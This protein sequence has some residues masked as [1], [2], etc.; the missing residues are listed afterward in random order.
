M[1]EMK[2]LRNILAALLLT[3]SM[4]SRADDFIDLPAKNYP[5]GKTLPT[6]FMQLQP[7]GNPG[8]L[9]FKLEYPEY[10]PL[11]KQEVAAIRQAGLSAPESISVNAVIGMSRK[12]CVADISFCPIICRKGKWLR[13]VSAKITPVTTATGRSTKSS[14][15]AAGTATARYADN[16]V[17]SSGKWLKIRVKEEGIYELTAA[18]L[19]EH[20]FSDINRVKIFGYGGRILPMKITFEG[21]DRLTDDLEEVATLKKG[22]ALLFFAEGTVRWSYDTSW[23]HQQNTYSTHSFYFV[24]EGENPLRIGVEEATKTPTD[25]LLSVTHNVVFENDAF[26]WYADGTRMFD[27]YEFVNGSSKTWRVATPDLAN[28][29]GTVRI[30][31]SAASAISAT[32]TTVSMGGTVLGTMS[33]PKLS[34][35]ESA[36]EAE[37]SYTVNNLLEENSIRFDVKTAGSGRLDFIRISYE[38]LLKA[39][40]APYSFTPN[41]ARPQALCIADATQN[42]RLWRIAS[43]GKPTMEM[44]GELTDGILTAPLDNAKA[45][46]V[47]ADISKSYPAPEVVGTIENQNLHADRHIDMVIIVPESGLLEAEAQRLADF[48][49]QKQGLRTKVVRANLIFNEFS[50]GTPDATAYRRYL[51]MLY[52]RASDIAD[53]PRYLLLFGDGAWDNRMVTS[54]WK[55]RN[56]KD[57]LLCFERNESVSETSV[58]IG[59]LNSYVTDD[60][61]G[62]LDDGEGA[63]ITREKIDL[64]IGRFPVHTAED[65]KIMVDKTIAYMENK[66]VG[67]WKNAVVVMGDNGDA[68][69]HMLDA[70]KACSA[71]E[72]ATDGKANITRMY[73]DVYTRQIA[74]TGYSF[75]QAAARLKEL[76]Q[77]GAALFNYSGHGSPDQISHSKLLTTEELRELASAKMPMWVLAS[78]EITPYDELSDNLGRATLVNENGGAI[79]MFCASRAVYASYN[80]RINAAICKYLFKNDEDGGRFSIGDATRMAKVAMIYDPEHPSDDIDHTMNKMKYALLGDPAVTLAVP[81]G[82]IVI[83]SINGEALTPGTFRRLAAGTK[84]VFSGHIENSTGADETDFNGSLTALLYD[85]AETVTCKNNDNSAA[86]PMTYTA[87]TNAVAQASD[88]VKNGKFRMTLPI[89]VDISYSNDSARLS[90]YAASNDHSKERNGYCN[91]FCLNG[92][93]QAI[94]NDREGPKTMVY[95]NEPDFP[96]GGTVGTTAVFMAE[97]SDESGINAPLKNVGHDIEL[98]IDEDDRSYFILNQNFT[99]DFGS[100]TSGRVTYAL[101]DLTPGQH[102]LRFRVWDTAGN[103]TTKQL[104]FTVSQDFGTQDFDIHCTKSPAKSSTTFT[105]IVPTAAAGTS[106]TFEVFDFAGRRIWAETM[107][108]TATTRYFSADWQLTSTGGAPVPAGVYLY[109]ARFDSPE[110]GGTSKTKKIIVVR[111]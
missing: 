104:R 23:S 45:R 30:G 75:P 89:P 82:N 26:G 93:S 56:P 50:S 86:K 111:Q 5:V 53:A 105:A 71:I 108:G 7:D 70:E 29:K 78:C 44:K 72:D 10:E 87:H 109:R 85:R 60:Y 12:Q 24:T 73:W 47:I 51:K 15:K 9:T 76:I 107:S 14:T 102:E 94:E 81:T 103:A 58:A 77:N 3:L 46:Y 21:D 38:R 80:N 33:M 8:N 92:T 43:A 96:D 20:G 79:A 69:E 22:N 27:D 16:S 88:S 18:Q 55:N 25:T 54:E 101:N 52:D 106:V 99:Y 67:T 41:K 100:I 6:C 66:E 39:T 68:N 34:S 13:L 17:L 74:A 42:T 4:G 63:S 90:L 32:S 59:S 91:A 65:A 62:L 83:D 64:G 84:A 19:A 36:R 48:H 11:T 97:M 40:S 61:F 95:L 35:N 57:F 1:T 31:F 37:R 49:T 110:G 2:T 28:G 98:T